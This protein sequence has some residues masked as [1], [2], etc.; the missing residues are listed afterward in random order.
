MAKHTVTSFPA[1]GVRPEQLNRVM[2]DYLALERARTFRRLLVRRLGLLALVM[3]VIGVGFHWL[4]TFAS[5]ISVGLCLV[6][7]AWAWIAEIRLERRL[8]RRLEDIPDRVTEIVR[9]S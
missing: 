9:E 2:A 8:A 1:S 5:W 4:P 3:V 6:P 7:S